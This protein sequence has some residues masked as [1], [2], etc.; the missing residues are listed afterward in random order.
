MLRL[1]DVEG[2]LAQALDKRGVPVERGTELVDASAEPE[3]MR[4][5]LRTDGGVEEATARFVAG[6]DGPAS[7]VRTIAAI[8]WQGGPYREEVV[9]ADLEID[10]LTPGRLHV[11]AGR[12]GLVFVFA[13]G[14]G[15]TWRLLDTRQRQTG[16][17]HVCTP[18]T[19]AH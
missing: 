1:M 4:V 10:G 2:V 17:A 18:V 7:T 15:A 13:L 9:L 16:R 5:V 12:E 3:G 19:N 11:V 6:C 14:E 8:G